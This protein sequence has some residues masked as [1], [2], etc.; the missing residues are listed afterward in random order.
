MNKYNYCKKI[1]ICF[2]CKKEVCLTQ[3]DKNGIILFDL[4][5]PTLKMKIHR[6]K[7]LNACV[8]MIIFYPKL[9]SNLEIC[10]CT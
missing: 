6:E 4:N 1:F 7:C 2:E 8:I 9:L 5:T 3:I 10:I